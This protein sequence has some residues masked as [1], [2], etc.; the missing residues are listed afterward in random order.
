MCL[1]TIKHKKPP[2]EIKLVKDQS[3]LYTQKILE[4]INTANI[5]GKLD[6]GVN[7]DPNANYN[8]MESIIINSMQKHSTCKTVKYNKYKHKNIHGSHQELS[9]H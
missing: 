3:A 4:D 7:A 6:S 9:N 8:I 2:T 5:I 1:K